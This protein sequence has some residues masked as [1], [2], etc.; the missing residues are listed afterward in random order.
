MLA[1]LFF[2]VHHLRRRTRSHVKSWPLYYSYASIL[3]PVYE[4][5]GVYALLRG[6]FPFSSATHLIA[7]FLLTYR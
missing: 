3:G 6:I 5:D 7:I 1:S 2:L 4:Q